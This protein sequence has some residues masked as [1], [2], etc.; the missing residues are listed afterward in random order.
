MCPA[1]NLCLHSLCVQQACSLGLLGFETWLVHIFGYVPCST[2][3]K[4]RGKKPPNIL[5][6]LVIAL[7]TLLYL[8]F[9]VL[10]NELDNEKF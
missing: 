8:L 2:Y 6:T 1:L 5:V 10:L 7:K 4:S 3:L 9:K